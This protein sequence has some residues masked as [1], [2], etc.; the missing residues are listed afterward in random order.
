MEKLFDSVVLVLRKVIELLLLLLII[1]LI[2]GLLYPQDPFGT[3]KTVNDTLKSL[4]PNGMAG[5]L[6]LFLIGVFYW[7]KR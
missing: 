6:T 2:V 7:R 1:G 3:L 5:L 4:S